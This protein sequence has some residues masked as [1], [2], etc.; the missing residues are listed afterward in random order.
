MELQTVLMLHVA[1]SLIALPLGLVAVKAYFAPTPPLW[2]RWFLIAAVATIGTGFLFPLPALTPAVLVG[3]VATLVL[4]AMAVAQ[5]AFGQ[6]GV[7]RRVYALG[8]VASTYF[9]AFVLVAQAFLK[10]PPLRAL[11]PTGTEAPFAVAQIVLLA[12][13]VWIGYRTARQV[14]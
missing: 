6:A 13:F 8:M 4:A 2:T 7:W 12:V 14:G 5:F 10:V 11:A 3:I 9:L 1:V